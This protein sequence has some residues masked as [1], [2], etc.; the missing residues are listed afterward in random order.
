MSNVGTSRLHFTSSLL[1]VVRYV[2]IKI[3]I[4][5]AFLAFLFSMIVFL[6]V[7]WC[8]NVNLINY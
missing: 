5:K 6:D 4:I 2:N 7:L 3:I 1:T 8:K